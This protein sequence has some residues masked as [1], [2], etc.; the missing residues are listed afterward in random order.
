[1]KGSNRPEVDLP[2]AEMGKVCLRFAPE[3]SGYLHIGHAKA[4]LMNKYFAEK[5]NGKIIIRFDDTNP[6]KECNEFVE[7]LLV[8][9]NTLG[10]SNYEKLT[11]TY[12]YFPQLMEM[13]L[14]LI[15]EGK[16]YVDDTPREQMQ[17]ERMDGIDSKCR[18]NTVAENIDLWKEMEAG[19]QRGLL[20]C[21][22]GKLDMQDPNKTL[23]Y[24]VYYRCNL[25]PHHRV[26][27]KYKIYPAYDFACPF[28]DSVEG[29]TN[30]LRSSEYQDR[31]AQ[32]FRI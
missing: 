13:A 12:D 32:Y 2:H 28:V 6:S 4:V 14:K 26:G 30:A 17:K 27:S 25:T 21:L 29:I 18:K 8:D 16:A 1:M 23:R 7:S 31:K 9:I 10:I 11:F 24:L 19:S 3:P 5:Y 15:K 20:F 22:R